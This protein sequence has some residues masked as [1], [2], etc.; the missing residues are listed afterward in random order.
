MWKKIISLVFSF[1][2]LTISILTTPAKINAQS[3]CEG[4]SISGTSS[5]LDGDQ[6]TVTVSGTA[7]TGGDPIQVVIYDQDTTNELGRDTLYLPEGGFSGK[8]IT[9]TLPES[10]VFVTAAIVNVAQGNVCKRSG[11]ISIPGKTEYVPATTEG[12]DL[13]SFFILG[14][15]G[16]RTVG[17]V[18]ST[19]TV[20]VNLLI[21][22]LFVF[23]GIILFIVIIFSGFKFVYQGTKGKDEAKTILTTAITGFILM[24][25]AYWIVQIVKIITGTQIN[26]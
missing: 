25:V 22:N 24:I 6:I 19:P 12:V 14:G 5:R 8:K 11:A 9:I 21:K 13:N 18:Y 1:F 15:A 3:A 17:E 10:D 2:L 7:V 23:A 26:L 20:L 4:S 16:S